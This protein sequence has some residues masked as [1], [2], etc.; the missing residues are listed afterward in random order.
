[1][2]L[3]HPRFPVLSL[4]NI[5]RIP[6]S[7][8]DTTNPIGIQS[9]IYAL[10]APF[11]FLDDE[12][13]VKKGYV[14]VLPTDDLW[15]IAHR[16]YQRS[17]CLS[18]LS[19]LQLCLLLLQ[20]PPPNYAVAEPLSTWSLSCSALAIAENLGLNLDPSNW[21][22]PRKEIMLRRRLWWLTYTQHIWQAVVIARPSHINDDNWDVSEI[23]ANDFDADE[24]QD[25]EIK[26]L[27]L[28]QIPLCLAEINLTTIVADVLK[29]F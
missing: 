4:Q 1:M 12:L 19:S 25:R 11:T 8:Y 29:E 17:T 10:A 5:S 24:I 14:Q 22:L 9:A 18:H 7:N 13:S 28:R 3:V 23:T 26:A 15:G 16:S 27:V 6:G 20:M 2:R 21:R